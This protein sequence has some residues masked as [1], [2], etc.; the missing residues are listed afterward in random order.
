MAGTKAWRQHY[1]FASH[2]VDVG[3]LRYHYVDEGAG[4]PAVLVH[5]N[6]TWS[7]YW[8]RLVA[9][10]AEDHRAIAPDHIG[11]G[12]SDKPDR[13]RY[14]FTLQRRIDDFTGFMRLLDLTEPVTLVVH[15]WGGPI[16]LAWAVEHVDMVGRVVV[17]NTAAFGLPEGKKMP[18]ALAFARNR[19]FGEAFVVG[20]NGFVRGATRL[21]LTTAMTSEVRAGYSAPYGRRQERTAVLEFIKDIPLD[22]GHRS[23]AALDALDRHLSRLADVPMLICWGAQDFVFDDL[24]LDEWRRRFPTAEVHRFADAGHFVLEDAPDEIIPLVLEFMR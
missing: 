1:P 18:P 2:A 20:A 16:G 21:G 24:V 6:P 4:D 7:F 8:R 17:T 9:A 5:G 19:P 22:G 10:I 23:F 3:G 11:M 12:M 13:G 15:D 14:P